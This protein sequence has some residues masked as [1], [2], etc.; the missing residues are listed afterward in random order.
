MT[1]LMNDPTRSGTVEDQA[2][3]KALFCCSLTAIANTF[4]TATNLEY[5]DFSNN[6]LSGLLDQACGFA[7]SGF[8]A[9]ISLANNNISGSIPGCVLGLKNLVELRL[10]GNA[11]RGSM[12]AIQG[13]KS[14]K[15]VYLTAANQVCTCLKRIMP[16]PDRDKISCHIV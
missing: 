9:Q 7:K 10:D 11:L 8:L 2:A 1:N 3:V 15:L 4:S 16:S 5:L 14:S 13:A 6:S 12:P